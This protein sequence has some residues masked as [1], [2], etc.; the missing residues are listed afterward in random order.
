MKSTLPS[1]TIPPIA[2]S[3]S[4]RQRWRHLFG[5]TRTRILLLYALTMLGVVAM[6]VPIFRILLFAQVD[7]RVRADL[8]EELEEFQSTYEVWD[9]QNPD[10]EDALST[11]IDDFL[12][13][14]VPED[15]NFN[16][17]ILDGEFY[18]AKPMPLP[19]AIGVDS[20][21]MAQWTD[22]EEPVRA[23]VSVDNPNIGSIIYKTYILEINNEPEGVFVTAHLS[24]GERSEALAGVYVFVRV[25][26]VVVL[27]AFLL[28]WV[29]S[30][31][32][33]KPVQQLATTAKSINENNLSQ[34]LIVDGTG[35][36]AEL[37]ETFNTMMNRVQSAFDSQRNFINDASHELRTPLTIIQGHLEL[38]GEDPEEQQETLTIV[39][40]EIDRMGRFVNDLILLAKAER[41]DFLQLETLDIPTLTEEIFHKAAVLAERN[42]TLKNLESGTFIGDRQRVTGALI[43]LANNAVQHTQAEATIELGVAVSEKTVCFWVRDTGEGISLADQHRIFD[44]FA[45]AAN[46]YRRSDGAGLGLA[47]VK[48][49]VDAHG[50]RIELTSKVG[51]GS[52][53]TL[54]FPLDPSREGR[55]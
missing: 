43:N 8:R 16:I 25:A 33:L 41:T 13:E 52:T 37:A 44:R 28:A 19:E 3:S 46:S 51:L 17:I 12:A 7:E 27:A 1:P 11:F 49:I 50:G 45:R 23:I 2:A 40:D 26:I 29:A 9:A 5:S 10:T 39:M 15:D 30:N 42:W 20:Q 22:L 53:F 6:A 35:E 21:L 47:I 36:L 38:M 34:R 48:A 31:Q 4:L 18:R 24:A 54:C 14:E 32:I 55:R